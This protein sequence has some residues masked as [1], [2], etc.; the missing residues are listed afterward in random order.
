MADADLR[1]LIA[2]VTSAYA[3][4]DQD[5]ALWGKLQELGLSDLTGSDARGGSDAGWGEAVELVSA[6][7]RAG[8]RLPVGDSDLVAGWVLDSV[9][10]EHPQALRTAWWDDGSDPAPE[11]HPL[12]ERVTVFRVEN[13]QPVFT[14]VA[15]EEL[16]AR[17]GSGAW[18]ESTT[19]SPLPVETAELVALRASLVRAVQVV[20]A[21]ETAT[22][23]AVAHAASRSQFGQPLIKFQAVQALVADLASETALARAATAAAVRV[24][25]GH[26]DDLEVLRPAVAVARSCVGHG[27]AIVSRAVHQVV[28]AIGTTQ[29]HPLHRHTHAMLTWRSQFGD[30]RSADEQVLALALA[31][32]RFSDLDL[33][34]TQ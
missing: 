16:R 5:A 11:L 18:A 27:A 30:T 31:G 4:G 21:L 32:A 34:P 10:G 7:A 24:L 12:V 1:D 6:L 25:I 9:G 2:T 29:E 3:G 28:G 15:V 13:E 23:I 14:D 22:D 20:S 17:L 33:E 19:W 8:S 26:G